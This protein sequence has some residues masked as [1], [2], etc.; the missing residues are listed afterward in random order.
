MCETKWRCEDAVPLERKVS[1]AVGVPQEYGVGDGMVLQKDSANKM[2][3]R[4]KKPGRTSAK[5]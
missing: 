2:A 5:V 1:L 3:C 4:T